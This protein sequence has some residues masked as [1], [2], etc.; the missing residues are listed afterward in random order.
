V[1]RGLACCDT[2][3]ASRSTVGTQGS[4]DL[5]SL[6]IEG[7]GWIRTGLVPILDSSPDDGAQDLWDAD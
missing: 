2:C 7:L 5:Q 4:H 3:S 1:P 6:Q